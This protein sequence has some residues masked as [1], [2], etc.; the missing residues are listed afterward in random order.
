MVAIILFGVAPK[1]LRALRTEFN[2]SHE[3]LVF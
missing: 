2:R 1:E 3:H